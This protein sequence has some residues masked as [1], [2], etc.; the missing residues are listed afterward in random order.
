[1][2][3][4]L[5]T[6]DG[7][8]AAQVLSTALVG[9]L[10]GLVALFERE[11][12]Q[13]RGLP[14]GLVD[15]VVDRA[16]A[17]WVQTDDAARRDDVDV[18][19]APFCDVVGEL[20]AALPEQGA[21]PQLLVL[22]EA[23]AR[24]G[25]AVW[26][27][28]DDA[29]A[30]AHP[31][32]QWSELVHAASRA[33]VESGRTAEAARWQLS[34][35]RAAHSAVRAPGTSPGAAMSLVGAVQALAVA[36]VLPTA[37]V[38]PLLAPARLAL[39]PLLSAHAAEGVA[40]HAH[41]ARTTPHLPEEPERRPAAQRSSCP[42]SAACSPA[43]GSPLH[44]VPDGRPGRPRQVLPVERG[45][46]D[47]EPGVALA[48]ADRPRD[49]AHPQPRVAALLGVGRRPAPV[50]HEEH[51][52][53]VLGRTEVVRVQRPQHRVLGHAGVEVGHQPAEDRLAADRVVEAGHGL[54]L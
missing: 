27:A 47:R 34:A 30:A 23:V 48:L 43:S 49:V 26:S 1:V 54:P 17:A 50:L 5:G 4:T 8:A 16:V 38:E 13:E 52:Q 7:H 21:V 31:G 6:P 40:T 29:H 18:L 9:R 10:T 45:P 32:L 2:S 24:C 12:G 19:S 37:V 39:A 44:V 53:P 11:L 36:D 22:L 42:R 35:V 46:H 20:P 15:V 28:L 25:P 51:P 3:R 41:E 33:A 14:R